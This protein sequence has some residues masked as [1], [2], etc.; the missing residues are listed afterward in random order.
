MAQTDS[1]RTGN[2]GNDAQRASSASPVGGGS[3]GVLARLRSMPES[4]AS[5]AGVLGSM[6]IDPRC[7]GEVIEYVDR[8]SFYRIEHEVHSCKA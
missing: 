1:N 7:I 3:S 2:E 6:M 4:L 5:E 8:D